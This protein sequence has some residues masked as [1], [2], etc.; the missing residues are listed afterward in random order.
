MEKGSIRPGDVSYSSLRFDVNGIFFVGGHGFEIVGFDTS[1]YKP[2]SFAMVDN[3]KNLN[4]IN[5]LE[6]HKFNQEGID[7]IYNVSSKQHN[8]PP[9]SHWYRQL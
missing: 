9:K 6:W 8:L 3:S 1:I 7:F 5:D 4:S 2:L